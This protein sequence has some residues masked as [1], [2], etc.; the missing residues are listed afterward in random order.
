MTDIAGLTFR[1]C[2]AVCTLTVFASAA[3][4]QTRELGAPSDVPI[5]GEPVTVSPGSSALEAVN[6]GFSDDIGSQ[7][8][9]APSEQASGLVAAP[10][11]GLS[12]AMWAGTNGETALQSVSSAKPMR[13]HALNTLLRRALIVSAAPPTEADGF[14][15]TRAEALLRFGAAEDAS[16]LLGVQP[17][18]ENPDRA[19][20]SAES[21][22]L[23]GRDD[24]LCGLV[25]AEPE[26]TDSRVDADFWA[27]LRGYCLATSGDPLAPVAIGA[28]RDIGR[29][30]PADA[31]LLEAV[32]DESIAEFVPMPATETLDP[33]RL[34]VLRRLGRA[35][36]QIV[37]RAPLAIVSGLYAVESTGARGGLLAGERLEQ[38]G[39][40]T[41][42]ELRRLYASLSQTEGETPVEQRAR[43]MG[44]ALAEPSVESIGDALILAA[45]AQTI[46]GIAQA[47]RVLS[48][49]AN[50]LPDTDA[51]GAGSR[52]Y[53]I[54]D[55]FFLAGDSQSAIRWAAAQGSTNPIELADTA[56]LAAI[57][58]PLSAGSWQREHGDILRD[59]AKGGDEH[60]RRSLA[61]LAGFEIAPRPKLPNEGFLAAARQGRSAEAVF[62]VA[63]ALQSEDPVSARTLDTVIRTLRA[64]GLDEDARKLAIEVMLSARWQ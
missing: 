41:T 34:A 8:L 43:A 11:A 49:S 54:R 51:Q 27:T 55:G 36:G 3:H 61:A 20:T 38:A 47:A 1:A 37:E 19:R 29:I 16:S 56:A 50:G 64:A 40:L 13:Y 25:L 15:S 42:P 45:R 10:S 24:E 22:L 30:E 2:L 52:G 48:E 59:R 14:L 60:A 9:D 62:A 26:A 39:S 5:F 63:A 12:Q 28:M 4:A 46:G 44:R 7:T 6:G 57:A 58:D 31:L 17:F 35:G 32:L 53:A 33:L 18:S 23:I 21:A